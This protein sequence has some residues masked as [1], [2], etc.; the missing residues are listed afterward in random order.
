MFLGIFFLTV[1]TPS[2]DQKTSKN[3]KLCQLINI[4]EIRI[5]YIMM[6]TAKI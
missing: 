2:I 3:M 6:T 1:S 5:I 4:N